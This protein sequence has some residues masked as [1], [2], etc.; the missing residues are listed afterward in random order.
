[1]SRRSPLGQSRFSLHRR[2]KPLRILPI[3]GRWKQRIV[4]P[5]RS[6][7]QLKRKN[8]P[9][10]GTSGI[11]RDSKKRLLAAARKAA[12]AAY[13]PT[14]HFRVGA[15]VLSGDKVVSGCNIENASLGLTICAERVAVFNAVS[16]GQKKIDAIAISCPDAPS[17]GPAN[18]KMPCGS[19]RQVL[20]E[21][22]D[23]DLPVIIDG[24]GEFSLASLFPMPFQFKPK[25]PR[26][27]E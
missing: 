23:A 14:S 3:Y 5:K 20:A 24:V 16:N 1:M 25:R 9:K 15:A 10:V 18:L 11:G 4:L 8:S 2:P 21:F 13:C 17:A 27:G 12:T 7:L 19:C 6:E 22:G 26:T